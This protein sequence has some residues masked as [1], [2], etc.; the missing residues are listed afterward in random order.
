MPVLCHTGSDTIILLLIIRLPMRL[1]ISLFRHCHEAPPAV[2]RSARCC[3]RPFGQRPTQQ[4]VPAETLPMQGLGRCESPPLC[5]CATEPVSEVSAVDV[6]GK[7]TFGVPFPGVI[8]VKRRNYVLT[9]HVIRLLL[10]A[11][12]YYI[13]N[14]SYT[15]NTLC[16]EHLQTPY[17]NCFIWAGMSYSMRMLSPTSQSMVVSC[18][19]INRR[20]RGACSASSRLRWPYTCQV[21]TKSTSTSNGSGVVALWWYSAS[22]CTCFPMHTCRPEGIGVARHIARQVARRR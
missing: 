5:T 15:R 18:M 19:A 21:S 20:T 14:K 17:P 22:C 12:C 9:N 1:P 6:S 10:M 11:M 8:H 7:L 4:H 13:H 16:V 2:G 3:F